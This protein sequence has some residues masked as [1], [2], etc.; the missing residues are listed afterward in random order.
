MPNYLEATIDRFEDD[1]AV[2]KLEDGQTIDW[3]VQNLPEDLAEGDAIKIYIGERREETE[4]MAEKAR[5]IL[6]ELLK[7]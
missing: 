7:K 1:Y 5:A 4:D 2:V 3:P 6:K